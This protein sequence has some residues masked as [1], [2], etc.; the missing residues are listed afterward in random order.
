[1]LSART[2]EDYILNIV[3]FMKEFNEKYNLDID[4]LDILE[5]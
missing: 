4:I 1:M 3:T 5:G 2:S